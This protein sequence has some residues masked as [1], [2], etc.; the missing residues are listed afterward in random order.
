MEPIDDPHDEGESYAEQPIETP[1]SEAPFHDLEDPSAS[2]ER[3]AYKLHSPGNAFLATF[4]GGPLA[5]SVILAINYF[6]VGRAAAA[7]QAIL[8]GLLTTVLL[9]TISL[10][11]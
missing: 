11:L 7:W 8:L 6:R 5:A 4:L 3:P 10:K 9:L 1:A 2:I